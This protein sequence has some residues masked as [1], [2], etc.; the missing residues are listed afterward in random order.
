M[1]KTTPLEP[2]GYPQL[3]AIQRIDSGS[4]Q[5]RHSEYRTYQLTLLFRDAAEPRINVLDHSDRDAA[6]A[7]G[8]QLADLLEVPLAAA[9]GKRG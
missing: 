7:T 5:A 3:E 4:H 6:L 9:A 8:R 2:A 1:A